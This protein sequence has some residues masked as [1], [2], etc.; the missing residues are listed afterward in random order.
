MFAQLYNL[1][2][3]IYL[4]LTLDCEASARLTSDS[5]DRPLDW[6]EA[7]ANRLHRLICRKSRMLHR[8]LVNVESAIS[9]QALIN[10]AF[11]GLSESARVRIQRRLQEVTKLRQPWTEPRE[12]RD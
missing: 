2:A 11:A 5:F 1:A 4:V 12:D 6:S 3:K 10:D 9:R 7:V 8:Q